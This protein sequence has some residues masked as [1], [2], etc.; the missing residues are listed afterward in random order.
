[1]PDIEPL[2]G[3]AEACAGDQNSTNAAGGT[4]VFPQLKG[5]EA[6]EATHGEPVCTSGNRHGTRHV[7]SNTQNDREQLVCLQCLP[8]VVYDEVQL[9]GLGCGSSFCAR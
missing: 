5:A 3:T 1:M 7:P 4:S 6:S 8:V 9:C 2:F